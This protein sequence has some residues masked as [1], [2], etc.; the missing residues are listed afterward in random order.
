MKVLTFTSDEDL[1]KNK[2]KK[3]AEAESKNQEV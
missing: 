1:A 2:R 3:V